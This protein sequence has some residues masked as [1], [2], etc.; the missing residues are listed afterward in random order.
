MQYTTIELRIIIN[1]TEPQ[2]VNY[3][4]LDFML[5][6]RVFHTAIPDLSPSGSF[7]SR[8][9]PS[10]ERTVKASLA[11]QESLFWKR[12]QTDYV[13]ICQNIC[14]LSAQKISPLCHQAKI[15][16]A[17]CFPLNLDGF[18]ISRSVCNLKCMLGASGAC[19]HASVTVAF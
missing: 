17:V 2:Y 14:L 4:E 9:H 16:S 6:C 12:H 15:P 13:C 19:V 7:T 18:M 3:L 8:R 11:L 1:V 10:R 5:H